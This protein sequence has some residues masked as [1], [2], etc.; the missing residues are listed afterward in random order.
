LPV[1][2]PFHVFTSVD[3][4]DYAHL[5]FPPFFFFLPPK[6]HTAETF[7]SHATNS[8][9]DFPFPRLFWAT[10][11]L[12]GTPV[13]RFPF[14]S[15]PR[16]EVQPNNSFLQFDRLRAKLSLNVWSKASTSEEGFPHTLLLSSLAPPVS[17][18]TFNRKMLAASSR[19]L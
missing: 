6:F 1:L 5:F 19:F 13:I 11:H 14:S 10:C 16:C 15:P 9:S 8:Q 7:P 3:W 18:V 2:L 12:A 17:V 4:P